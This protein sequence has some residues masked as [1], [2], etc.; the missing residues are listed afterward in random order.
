VKLEKI[1]QLVKT[2]LCAIE[3]NWATSNN[4]SLVKLEKT[5]HP[6]TTDFFVKFKKIGQLVTTDSFMKL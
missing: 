5:R 2:D 3:K 1:G 6:V 4:R